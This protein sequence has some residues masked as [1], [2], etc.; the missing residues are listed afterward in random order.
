ML[1]TDEVTAPIFGLA[2]TVSATAPCVITVAIRSGRPVAAAE[3][4]VPTSAPAVGEFLADSQ[5]DE[6]ALV[7][8]A[9]ARSAGRAIGCADDLV[10]QLRA[11]HTVVRLCVHVPVLQSGVIW[12]SLLDQS[13]PG[14][15]VT[16]MPPRAGL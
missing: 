3:W 14:G 10:A 16:L 7:V 4:P 8:V 6:V 1:A 11:E 13:D 12:T 9:D 15:L 5:A 2:H